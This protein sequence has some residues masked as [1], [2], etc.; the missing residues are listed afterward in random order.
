[1]LKAS[2]FLGR[3]SSTIINNITDRRRITPVTPMDL[4]DNRLSVALD[5]VLKYDDVLLL[6]T[7]N[8]V[9]RSF[10]LSWSSCPVKTMC[11]LEQRH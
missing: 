5:F 1:M 7:L 4:E 10:N 8:R 11:E 6:L 9:E 3:I 2:Y